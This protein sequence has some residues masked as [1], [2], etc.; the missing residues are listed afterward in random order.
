MHTVGRTYRRERT[1]K[2]SRLSVRL[3]GEVHETS[4]YVSGSK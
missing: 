2:D 1:E 4:D 3:L